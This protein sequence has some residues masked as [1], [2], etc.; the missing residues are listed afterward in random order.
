MRLQRTGLAGSCMLVALLLQ[1]AVVAPVSAAPPERVPYSCAP[2]DDPC[3]DGV[4]T[5]H[6]TVNKNNIVTVI[7]DD[8]R[9]T[10]SGGCVGFQNGT[11]TTVRHTPIDDNGIPEHEHVLHYKNTSS[12]VISCAGMPDQECQI[13]STYQ[14]IDD[15]LKHRKADV[16]CE[17]IG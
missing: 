17:A 16:T 2:G 3:V 13:T 1:V 5:I 14:I 7:R 15:V 4:M 11:Q 12:A 10:I 6:R 9:L 8:Y